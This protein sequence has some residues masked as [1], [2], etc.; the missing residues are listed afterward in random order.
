MNPE[1]LETAQQGAREGVEATQPEQR[2]AYESLEEAIKGAPQGGGR[3]L[4]LKEAAV[5]VSRLYKEVMKP[6]VTAL[7]AELPDSDKLFRKSQV[8]LL[9]LIASATSYVS[10]MVKNAKALTTEVKARL[11]KALVDDAMGLKRQMLSVSEYNLGHL[12]DVARILEDVRA[13]S[14]YIDLADDLNRLGLLYLEHASLLERDQS[15]YDPADAERAFSLDAQIVEHLDA[16]RQGD[17][18]FWSG[19]AQRLAAL[20]RV[21]YE[22]VALTARWLLRGQGVDDR[23]P[24]LFQR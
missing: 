22:D 24:S 6:D 15:K 23:F 12:P 1:T 7:M 18:A 13:G 11:P 14:G 8:P 19:Q 16:D 3:G 20:L 17:A 9:P 4:N 21:T 5:K 2:A 10:A